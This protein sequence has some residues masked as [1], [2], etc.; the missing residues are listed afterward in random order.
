MI[1]FNFNLSNINSLECVLRNNQKCKIGSET[2]NINNNEPLFNPYSIKISKCKASCNSIDDPHANLCV[3]NDIKNIN[4]KVFNVVSR[5]NE[6]KHI[7]W[8][9]NV[10]VYVD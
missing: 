5:T 8:H 10:N 1:F 6:T 2:F 3:P 7:E 4:V 9:K